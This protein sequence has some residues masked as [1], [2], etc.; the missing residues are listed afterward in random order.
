MRVDVFFWIIVED[1]SRKNSGDITSD[2]DDMYIGR[3]E[4]SELL[5]RKSG[6]RAEPSKHRSIGSAF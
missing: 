2:I 5:S 3:V 1:L 6:K 4:P